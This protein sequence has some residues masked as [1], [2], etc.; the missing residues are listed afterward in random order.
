MQRANAINSASSIR[1]RS[2]VALRWMALRGV[3]YT[4]L[5]LLTLVFGFP[6]FWTV[7][8]SLKT[9]PELGIF[10]PL[11]FPREPQW[12][13]YVRVFTLF[14]YPVGRWF[15]NSTYVVALST[16][17]TMLTSTLV[18]YGFARF[19]F[20]GKSLLFM[21]TLGTMMLPSQ[22]TLIPQFLLFYNIDWVNTFKPL[23]V[24]SW[25]GGGA[26]YIFL[27]RQFFMTLPKE[28]DEAARIDG[29]NYWRIFWS[30]LM[31][32]CKP[33][34]ATLGIIAF[35]E[36][37]NSFVGPLIYLNRSQQYT[38]AVGLRF[39]HMSPESAYREP[40]QNV[41]MAATI[42]TLIPCLAIFFGGQ[43]YFIRGIVMSGI[44]G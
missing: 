29:A 28:F 15:L 8:T 42:L 36:N 10:P 24:P 16:L 38:V 26:F 4:T 7:T 19:R 35:M 32:L 22:V 39:F 37:W 30:V 11:V 5:L 27:M 44:K 31:P 20:R 17:G 13:N 1:Y 34:L 33:A 41:L 23:W 9:G 12:Q 18:A 14:R 3:L 43:T 21:V 25:F 40:I 6:F 2:R